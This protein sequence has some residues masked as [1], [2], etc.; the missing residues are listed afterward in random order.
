MRQRER[1]TALSGEERPLDCDQF[2][3]FREGL[4]GPLWGRTSLHGIKLWP[5]AS[6]YHPVLRG[7]L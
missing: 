4:L 5:K 3:S 7:K 1:D 2:A 6:Y